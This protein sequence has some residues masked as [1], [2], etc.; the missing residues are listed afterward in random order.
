MPAPEFLLAPG[1]ALL[2]TATVGRS[3]A[4][5]RDLARLVGAD[6]VITNP[7]ELFCYSYDS[8]TVLRGTLPAAV[9]QPTSTG[10]VAAVLRYA[11]QQSLPLI[12]RG[13]GTGLSG[14]C[15]PLHQELILDVSHLNRL[16][17]VQP[18]R[19]RAI[20]EPGVLTGD[21]QAAVEADGLF[22]PP[23]PSSLKVSSIGE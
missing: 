21:L 18:A 19:R 16:R 14:G 3:P 7:T 8:T 9:V 22:Y 15:V 12:P 17:A 23:D 13:S 20:A 4:I 2:M 1:G 6:R 5:G 11:Q 10:Q